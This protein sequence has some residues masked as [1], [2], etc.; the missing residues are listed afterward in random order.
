VSFSL[1]ISSAT[2]P[3]SRFQVAETNPSTGCGWSSDKTTNCAYVADLLSA[4]KSLGVNAGWYSSPG[5]W[6][7]VA[8][9]CTSAADYPLWGADYSIGTSCSAMPKFGG[10]KNMVLLQYSDAGSD[11]SASYDK[12]VAC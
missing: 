1:S 7:D 4:A 10:F 9:D 11:C 12:D 8:G 2:A 3:C 5:E 6:D